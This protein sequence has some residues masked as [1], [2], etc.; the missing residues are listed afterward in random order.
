MKELEEQARKAGLPPVFAAAKASCKLR[1]SAMNVRHDRAAR[2]ISYRV[3]RASRREP[4]RL[5]RSS[6]R[7]AR[8][9]TV[10]LRIRTA[11]RRVK[12]RKLFGSRLVV[13]LHR[14]AAASGTAKV[15]A[16]FK[17]R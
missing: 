5:L 8:N 10:T 7:K 4:A 1:F 14:P 17:R 12:L 9:G 13:G 16:A 11:S 3:R 6:C 2:T 15:Q